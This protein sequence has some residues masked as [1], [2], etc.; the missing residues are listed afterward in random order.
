M[1][2]PH[3]AQ[4]IG[5]LVADW[6]AAAVPER[7][8]LQGRLC[9]LEPLDIA[10]HGEA[11]WQAI[12][13]PGGERNWTYLPYGPFADEAAYR[14][15]LTEMAGQRDPLFFAVVERASGRAVGVASF[16]RIAP[17]FECWLAPGNFDEQGR[18]RELLSALTQR[19]HAVR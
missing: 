1:P 12:N 6:Q 13:L 9:R 7:R 11:L 3:D 10:A 19:A 16:L 15:W 14:D 5:G 17:A 18:Q 4:P 8:P 2:Q